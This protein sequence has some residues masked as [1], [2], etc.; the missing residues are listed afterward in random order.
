MPRTYFTVPQIPSSK[1]GHSFESFPWPKPQSS[2][3]FSPPSVKF[4]I[5]SSNP[6]VLLSL[7]L[8]SGM[9]SLSTDHF[10]LD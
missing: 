3:Q 6:L 5:N 7:I 1:S 9:N 4:L 2:V 10:A 8:W